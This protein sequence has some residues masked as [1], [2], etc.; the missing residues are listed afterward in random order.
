MASIPGPAGHAVL[1]VSPA[2]IGSVVW[3]SNLSGGK[4]TKTGPGLQCGLAQSVQSGYFIVQLPGTS[5]ACVQSAPESHQAA[6]AQLPRQQTSFCRALPRLGA[7]HCRV[8]RSQGQTERPH[9]PPARGQRALRQRRIADGRGREGEGKCGKQPGC[10]CRARL[11]RY[12]R[13][14]TRAAHPGQRSSRRA[15]RTGIV[16]ALAQPGREA[17]GS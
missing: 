15:G 10:E 13:F 7:S 6:S 9:A 4:L 2:L 3:Q 5:C 12:C 11:Y 14:G 1:E 17:E 8:H 16:W